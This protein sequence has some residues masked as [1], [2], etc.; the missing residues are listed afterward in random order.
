M[1]GNLILEL[2]ALDS[3]WEPPEGEV[4]ASHTLSSPL[5]LPLLSWCCRVCLLS[6]SLLWS[7]QCGQQRGVHDK[8]LVPCLGPA[9]GKRPGGLWILEGAFLAV[10]V[11]TLFTF[12][13]SKGPSQRNL[14]PK[15]THQTRTKGPIYEVSLL[16]S[17]WTTAL[18]FSTW[19][20]VFFFLASEVNFLEFLI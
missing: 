14:L 9:R 5:H 16:L 19:I 13:L 10:I 3:C 11:C 7:S 20:S 1:C 15:A 4:K 8:T 12:S 18:H 6:L 2:L 17:A